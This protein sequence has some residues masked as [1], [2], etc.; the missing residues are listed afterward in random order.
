[1]PETWRNYRR[2]LGA[3]LGFHI[4]THSDTVSSA[5]SA[6]N[7][8]LIPEL[9]GADVESGFLDNTWE[10]QPLDVNHGEVRRVVSGGLSPATGLVTLSRAHSFNTTTTADIEFYGVLPPVS[11]LGRRGLLEAANLALEECWTIDTLALTGDST[12]YQYRLDTST[13]TVYSGF[14]WLNREDQIIDVFI[15]RS[16]ET[17]DALLSQWR[18]INDVDTPYLEIKSPLSTA[19][20]IKPL[21]YR[22][23]GTW[24]KPYLQSWGAIPTSTGLSGID[25]D[26][27]LL[28][29]QGMLAVGLY[30]CYEFLASE[31]D[32]PQRQ[33]WRGMADRQRIKANK[34]KA[35]TLP[36]STG[37]EEHWSR[38][39]TPSHYEWPVPV[40]ST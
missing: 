24:I 18:L 6:A 20:T 25:G 11:Y 4:Y 32:Y 9:S 40:L 39:T 17:R 15:R 28:S 33:Y 35:S 3:A 22:P 23:M 37:R 36:R 12:S 27:A 7:V 38:L 26:Q 8:I 1:M 21:V 10:Y 29:I 34:W 13:H 19:D 2:A 5:S 14:P 30:W 31:G 16:G